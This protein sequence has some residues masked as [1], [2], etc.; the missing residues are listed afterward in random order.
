MDVEILINGEDFR[1]EK[2]RII[3]F[4]VLWEVSDWGIKNVSKNVDIVLAP[5][6]FAYGFDQKIFH[7]FDAYLAAWILK[8]AN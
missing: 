1:K 3:E 6:N 8:L 5:G 2:F 7:G 4:E